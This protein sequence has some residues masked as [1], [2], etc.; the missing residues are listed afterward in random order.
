MGDLGD[1]HV[2][3]REQVAGLADAQLVEIGDGG[4]PRVLTE[5]GREM[6]DRVTG[7]VGH[8]PERHT[9]RQILLHEVDG[10]LDDIG[11]IDLLGRELPVLVHITDGGQE[12]DEEPGHVAEVLDAVAVAEGVH[13]LVEEIEAVADAGEQVGL[14]VHGFCRHIAVPDGAVAADMHPEDGPGTSLGGAVGMRLPRGQ[15]E[16]AA[17][18]DLSPGLIADLIPAL[19]FLNDDEDILRDGFLPL[20][21]VVG[22]R[23]IEPDVGDIE[24]THD[25]VVPHHLDDSLGQDD[26]PLA[27]ESGLQPETVYLTVGR[28]H[29]FTID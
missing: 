25:G 11:A 10:G 5:D 1:G 19:P 14:Q 26:G 2:G 7:I 23:R 13:D 24:V 6:G 15:Q 20:A 21:V 16:T 29:D 8:L 22:R 28:F 17:C 3:G 18:R 27:G 4:K 9:A 12:E